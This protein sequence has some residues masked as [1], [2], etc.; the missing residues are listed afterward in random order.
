MP[1]ILNQNKPWKKIQYFCNKK[2]PKILSLRKLHL[3]WIEIFPSASLAELVKSLRAQF[4]TS[5]AS[6][7]FA[8]TPATKTVINIGSSSYFMIKNFNPREEHFILK[9]S[10][11]YLFV[12]FSDKIFYNIYLVH[13]PANI[14][15]VW[16]QFSLYCVHGAIWKKSNFD[17]GM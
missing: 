16:P 3:I 9:I 17:I 13:I 8:L 15:F 10:P 11:T 12:K 14:H 2:W 4:A 5:L 1:L 7:L 6:P